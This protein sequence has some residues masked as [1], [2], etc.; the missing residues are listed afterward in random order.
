MDK[1]FEFIHFISYKYGLDVESLI[2]DYTEF[3]QDEGSKLRE[4]GV[5]DDY[6]NFLDKNE[7]TLNSKFQKENTFETSVRGLKIRGVFPT[8]EEAEL[9]CKK[10]RESDPN[11]DILVG[12]VGLWLPWDPDAYKT[13]RVEFM[14]D[15]LNQ[16]HSEKMKNESK[17][18]E[19]FEKR[20]K[21][22]KRKAIEDN[23]KKAE[24]S[25]NVLTQTLDDQGNLVGVQQT[26]DFDE[27]EAT[28]EEETKKYN[29]ELAQ[30]LQNDTA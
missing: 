18:K 25:G 16:L 27:R 20:V 9:K 6:K 11:H 23:I 26:V 29:E 22:A 13:Q 12:P 14:E 4:Q 1:F 19:E 30:K 24:K 28:T 17:A 3:V 10:L 5:E 7:D 2:S 8:Q 15:E 21:D